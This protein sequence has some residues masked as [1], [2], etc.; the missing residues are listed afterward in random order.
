VS[1]ISRQPISLIFFHLKRHI[2]TIQLF[3]NRDQRVDRSSQLYVVVVV[4]A[5]VLTISRS[6][7]CLVI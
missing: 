2:N 1:K 4:I 6:S 3:N 5:V 7:M